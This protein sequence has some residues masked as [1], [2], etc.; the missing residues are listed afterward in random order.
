MDTLELQANTLAIARLCWLRYSEI[1]ASDQ[2]LDDIYYNRRMEP[3]D[4]PE[5][6]TRLGSTMYGL[7]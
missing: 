7:R 4:P 3:L 5:P 6:I 2:L 1:E